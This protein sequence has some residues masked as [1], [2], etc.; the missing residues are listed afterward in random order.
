MVE[1]G[2]GKWRLF[3]EQERKRRMKIDKNVISAILWGI[4]FWLGLA[5]S[6]SIVRM[7]IASLGC[8]LALIPGGLISGV[9][10]YY[11]CKARGNK[12]EDKAEQGNK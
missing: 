4:A 1:W 3:Y 12:K 8:L 9:G 2:N 5:L 11:I 10:R 6:Y 7:R